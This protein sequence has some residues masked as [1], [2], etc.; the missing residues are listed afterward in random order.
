MT[1]NWENDMLRWFYLGGILA[2]CSEDSPNHLL[3]GQYPPPV[4]RSL[5]TVMGCNLMRMRIVCFEGTATDVGVS[6]GI[7]CGV[8]Q[9]GGFTLWQC[10]ARQRGLTSCTV[11]VSEGMSDIRL[12]VTDGA[13]DTTSAAIS[14]EVLSPQAPTVQIL[15]P[16]NDDLFY[17][18]EL[19]SFEAQVG[20][21]ETAPSDLTLTWSSSI[22]GTLPLASVTNEKRL[23]FQKSLALMSGQHDSITLTA[24]DEAGLTTSDTVSIVVQGPNEAPICALSTP[25]DGSVFLLGEPISLSA[26][27]T[28]INQASESLAVIWTSSIDGRLVQPRQ[29]P[30]GYQ[31]LKWRI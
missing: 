9:W 14:I 22:G 10:D 30:L 7:D 23:D 15:S 3:R 8:V 31:P 18:T 25:S 5:H 6:L 11:Q 21:T 13:G 27:V 24:E 26:T 28:D 12:D 4:Q 29:T 1:D 16:Q 17:S 20:D 2:A 19:I